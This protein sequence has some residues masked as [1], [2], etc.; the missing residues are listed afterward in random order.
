VSHLPQNALLTHEPYAYKHTHTLIIS[1]QPVH[2][3][4]HNHP[5]SLQTLPPPIVNITLQPPRNQ[6]LHPALQPHLPQQR[7]V[8][9]LVEE[10][11][12][13]ASQRRIHLTMF[14]EVRGDVPGAVV[15]VEEENHAFADVQEEADLAAASVVVSKSA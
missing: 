11:L 8:P 13:V 9:L 6:T 10:E 15:E 3:T 1:T 4:T 5:I 7:I 12:V 2:Q 14:I